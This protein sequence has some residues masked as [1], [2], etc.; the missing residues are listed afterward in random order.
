VTRL[1]HSANP[2]Q[3]EKILCCWRGFMTEPEIARYVGVHTATVR[4]VLRLHTAEAVAS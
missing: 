2:E 1:N 4:A 3:E